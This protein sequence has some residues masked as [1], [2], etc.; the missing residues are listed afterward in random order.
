MHSNVHVCWKKAALYL[1]IWTRYC[2]CTSES[3]TIDPKEA[4]SLVD[5]NTILVWAILGSTYLENTMIS[6]RL[7]MNSRKSTLRK[8]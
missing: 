6:R 1:E 3:Y 5:E 8:T 7:T 2:H 4:A